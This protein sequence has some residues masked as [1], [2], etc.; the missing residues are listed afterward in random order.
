MNNLIKEENPCTSENCG[1]KFPHKHTY[2]D[3]G[4]YGITPLAKKNMSFEEALQSMR[5]GK[6]VRLGN[7]ACGFIIDEY[8]DYKAIINSSGDIVKFNSCDIMS[9][10][11]EEVE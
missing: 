10:D 2:Y 9:N 3:N 6:T 1:W 5:L 4:S 11:W 8:P 7:C